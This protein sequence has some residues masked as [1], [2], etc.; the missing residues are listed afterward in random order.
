MGGG[1][2]RPAP[3]NRRAVD[4]NRLRVVLTLY[5]CTGFMLSP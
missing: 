2:P 3:C 4:G 1:F 5:S